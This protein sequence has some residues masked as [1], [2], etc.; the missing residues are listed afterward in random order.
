MKGSYCLI[1]HMRRD[2]SDSL[3][4]GVFYTPDTVAREL[5]S[6]ARNCVPNSRR[7]RILDP[8]C[9]D[10]ALLK[11]TRKLLGERQIYHGC[12]IFHPPKTAD[13]SKWKF[14]RSNF[15]SYS[16]D[17]KYDLVIA[18][19]P[20]IRAGLLTSKEKDKRF[21]EFKDFAPVS[22]MCDLWAYFLLKGCMHLN[23]G[24]TIA[25]VVP[26]AFFEAEFAH[27][28]REWFA[29]KFKVVRVLVLK[30]RL[31]EKT[32]KQVLLVWMSGYNNANR[33]IQIGFSDRAASS[34]KYTKLN[35]RKW[36]SS[37]LITD[38]GLDTANVIEEFEAFGLQPISEYASVSIGTVT[39][40]NPYFIMPEEIA[41]GRGF[42]HS[43]RIPILTSVDE[44]S[45]LLANVE[46]RKALI[47]F[48]RMTRKRK[49]YI[50][51]GQKQNIHL[52][53]HCERRCTNGNREWYRVSPGPIAD[54][55]F[56]YRIAKIPYMSLNTKSLHCTNALHKVYFDDGVTR[57]QR[58]W[59]VLS[60][61][62]DF[63]QLSLERYGRHY[64]NGVLKIEPSALKNAMVYVPVRRKCPPDA[65]KEASR[66]LR[67][68]KKEEASRIATAAIRKYAHITKSLA[69]E[70]ETTLTAIRRRRL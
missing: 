37:S 13:L 5:A 39:G 7:L 18:N 41:E 48:S 36:N 26:W 55:F 3:T 54:A 2:P 33:A 51:L 43:A 35:G 62:S 46:P 70:V 40:A 59:V 30:D 24:G 12:D 9:G 52:R 34:H 63:S 60:V 68:G 16:D 23:E 6:G 47:Q 22:R 20:Y 17:F 58:K 19:P 32:E 53:S 28:L 11:A 1:R 27:P 45:G 64:G 38:V 67:A 56:T 29:K 21:S 14:I 57:E 31:F 66:L 25:A 50:R 8:S 61:L 44:L 69:A 15:F 65:F 42:G 10:G 4:N 49:S